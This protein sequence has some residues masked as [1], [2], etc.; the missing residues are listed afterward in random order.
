M[1]HSARTD[2]DGH[3][4]KSAR[5]TTQRSAAAW[6]YPISHK[7]SRWIYHRNLLRLMLSQGLSLDLSSKFIAFDVVART[8]VGSIIA[9]FCV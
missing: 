8:L 5:D 7:D 1:G 4:S 2:D 9:T 3:F 6:T